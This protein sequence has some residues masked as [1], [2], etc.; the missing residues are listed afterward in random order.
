MIYNDVEF[1]DIN[2][3]E[4]EGF[5]YLAIFESDM[6]KELYIKKA[7][8]GCQKPIKCTVFV[9]R[10][11]VRENFL[12]ENGSEN[13]HEIIAN[14]ENKGLGNETTYTSKEFL[15]EIVQN[16]RKTIRTQKEL[17]GSLHDRLKLKFEAEE[18]QVSEPLTSI[19]H[20]VVDEKLYSSRKNLTHYR[21]IQWAVS[22]YSRSPA[23][24]KIMKS[25]IRM[26]SVSIL[27]S[28][29][30]ETEQYT[31]WQNKIVKR[32]VASMKTNNVWDMHVLICQ[33]IDFDNE[34]AELEAFG[35]Q[36]LNNIQGLSN[37]IKHDNDDE[38]NHERTLVTQIHQIVWHSV[39]YS[40]NFSIVYFGVEAMNIHTLSTILFH[41]A[42]KL[43]CVAIHTCGFVCDSADENRRHIKSFDWFAAI[44]KVNDKVEVHNNWYPGKVLTEILVDNYLDIEVIIETTEKVEL[45]IWRSLLHDI[46]P[47]YDEDEHFVSHLTINLITGVYDYTTKHEVTKATK[48]TKRHIWL[49]PWS[50]M[51]VDLAE[52]TLSFDVK[53]AIENISEL[54]Y[55]FQGTQDRAIIQ[56]RRISQDMLEG[57]FRTIREIGGDSSIQTV[58]SYGYAMNKLTITMQMTLEIQSL[59]YGLANSSGC[60]FADLKQ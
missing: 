44:W 37:H 34:N 22:I 41:L 38:K 25:V 20:N 48:L 26:P 7:I 30:N 43:K 3:T 57:L 54:N 15:T 47:E 9:N 51:R 32:M 13:N 23:T 17:V 18:E 11:E 2:L 36:C 45:Y 21:F 31:G 4:R 10:L 46:R 6:K 53:K 28:Y 27:K 24:Y 49:T 19:V 8:H 59:N 1:T 16:A 12:E 50:K 40:F 14:L 35:E 29:I 33:I 55:I 58:Q 60:I 52:Y 39:S 5:L 56:P 42:A